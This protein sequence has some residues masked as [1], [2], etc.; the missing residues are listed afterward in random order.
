[1]AQVISCWPLTTEAW[2]RT[3][4]SPCGDYSEQ[5]GTGTGF[6]PNSSIFLCQYHSTIYL[7]DEQ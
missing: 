7:E 3:H 2:I 6:S 4:V 5:S 1:M